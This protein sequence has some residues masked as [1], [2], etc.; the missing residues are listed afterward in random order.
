MTII[1]QELRYRIAGAEET[2]WIVDRIPAGQNIELRAV[3]RG[4]TYDVEIRNVDHTGRMSAPATL[5]HTVGATIREGALALPVNSVAN[6]SSV[7]DVDTSVTYSAT[8]SVATLSVSAGTL[9][10]GGTTIHYNA[11]S[12]S[13]AGAPETS[14][15]VYLYYDDPRLAGGTVDLGVTE[16]YITSMSGNGRVA[17][18]A[19][20]ITFPAVGAPPSTGG[21]G[22]GGGGGGGGAKNPAYDELPL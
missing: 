2:E 14:K 5:Q 4:V 12:A 17:I 3:R 6:I 21:G 22:I 20:K 16:D 11:S 8:D 19:V 15:T 9:V 1:A 10:I 7:W 13:V 18:T